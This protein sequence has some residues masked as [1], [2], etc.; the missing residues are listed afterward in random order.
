VAKASRQRR[1]ME[2]I[3]APRQWGIRK[4][5]NVLVISP[6]S[7]YLIEPETSGP[8]KWLFLS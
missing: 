2:V 5:I 4:L 7:F 6:V 1:R 3:N 8:G